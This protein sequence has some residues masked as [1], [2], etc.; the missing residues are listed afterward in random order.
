V[1]GS[2]RAD[3]RASSN[4]CVFART[5]DQRYLVDLTNPRHPSGISSQYLY[6]DFILN[7]QFKTPLRVSR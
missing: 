6:A 1:A 2:G 5:D 4:G 7:N 3:Q